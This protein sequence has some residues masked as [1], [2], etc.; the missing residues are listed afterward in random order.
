[1][2]PNDPE[3]VLIVDDEEPVRRTFR[4]WLAGAGLGCRVLTAADAAEALALAGRQR[5][6]LALLDW[7]LGAGTHGLQL[8]EDLTEFSPDVVAILITAYADQA[9]PLDAMRKGVRDY[10]DKNRDLNR[11]T[12]LAAVRRQLERIRPLRRERHVQAGLV[13]F[14]AA[15]AQVLPL[16]QTAAALTDPVPLPAAVTQLF[17]FLLTA[18]G[19]ADGA[20]VVHSHDPTR[21]P[22]EELRAYDVL[23]RRHD[24][25]LAPF[26]NS[27]AALVLSRQE[28]CVLRPPG[29][30]VELHAFEQNR[31]ALLA[32]PVNVGPGVQAVLELFDAPEGFRDADRRLAAAAADFSAELLRHALAERQTRRVLFDAVEAALRSGDALAATLHG[33]PPAPDEPPPQAVLD[34]LREGLAAGADTPADAADT[35][36]LAEAVRALAARHGPAALRHCQRLVE[37]VRQLLDAVTG[38]ESV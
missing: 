23:G 6:D 25:P 10:L 35:L 5:V 12:F 15:V 37:S 17:R 31:A 4:D 16:V 9:T 8:L 19:A 38:D 3:V 26:R 34:S 14:R 13:A 33:A 21:D 22:P 29:D 18:T 36:R 20:L 7:N 32:A 2:T 11:D 27:L 24:G 30:G 1:M 28:A